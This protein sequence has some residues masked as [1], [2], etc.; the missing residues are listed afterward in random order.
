MLFPLIS[1]A[2][3]GWIITFKRLEF[4]L[5]DTVGLWKGGEGNDITG[6]SLVPASFPAYEK[7]KTGHF[8][9]KNM[10]VER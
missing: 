4:C 9:I 2:P 10:N 3:S 6:P 5:G 8:L 1:T 7:N